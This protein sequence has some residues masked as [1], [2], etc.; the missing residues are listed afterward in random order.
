MLCVGVVDMYENNYQIFTLMYHSLIQSLSELGKSHFMPKC[1]HF[2]EASIVT[3]FLWFMF[4][5]NFFWSLWKNSLVFLFYELNEKDDSGA[6]ADHIRLLVPLCFRDL[7][8]GNRTF[9]EFSGNCRASVT[10]MIVSSVDSETVVK[11]EAHFSYLSTIWVKVGTES[12]DVIPLSDQQFPKPQYS[13]SCRH[14]RVQ[15]GFFFYFLY[16][17]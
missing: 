2:N 5:W 1:E 13:E 10:W 16:I 11:A 17:S 14:L 12:S 3:A 6:C 4:F 7:V 15:K 8:S 9:V